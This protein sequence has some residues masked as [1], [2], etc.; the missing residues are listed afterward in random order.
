MF[1]YSILVA[2]TH[3]FRCR[4]QRVVIILAGPSPIHEQEQYVDGYREKRLHLFNLVEIFLYV[5]HRHHKN[6]SLA[7]GLPHIICSHQTRL[8]MTKLVITRL[9]LVSSN[10][11]CLYIDSIGQLK[12]RKCKVRLIAHVYA[13]FIYQMTVHCTRPNFCVSS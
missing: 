9:R 8:I 3:D 10:P 2:R 13:A 7:L 5:S 1:D 4:M 11:T 12:I 6:V